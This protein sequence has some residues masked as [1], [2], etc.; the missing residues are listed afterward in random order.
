MFCAFPPFKN[1]TKF[2]CHLKLVFPY[3]GKDGV[4]LKEATPANVELNFSACR[5]CGIDN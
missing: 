2:N 3:M 4:C 5:F 1:C